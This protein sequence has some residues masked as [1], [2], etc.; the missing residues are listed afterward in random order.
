M[1]TWNYH[2][3]KFHTYIKKLTIDVTFRFMCCKL[4]L[5][6]FSQ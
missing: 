6:I 3:A 4:A 2:Y 5:S 1:K